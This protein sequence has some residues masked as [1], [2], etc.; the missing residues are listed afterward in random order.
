MRI[1]YDTSVLVA[2]LVAAHPQHAAAFEWLRKAQTEQVIPLMCVHS[3]GECYAV[4]T[5]LPVTPRIAPETARYLLQH[6][7]TLF[8]KTSLSETDYHW[9]IEH[10]ARLGL[11]G[12]IAY[13]ALILKA[14]HKAKA[15]K[16]LTLNRRDFVRLCPEKEAFVLSP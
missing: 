3:L 7:L 6:N 5:R 4:L 14:A 15:E 11:S 13:D 16:I 2:G 12:G 9:A 10:I 8:T 1:L